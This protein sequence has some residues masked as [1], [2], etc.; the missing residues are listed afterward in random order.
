MVNILS[1][2][3]GI[4]GLDLALKL[5]LGDSART[6]AYVE[7]EAYCCEVLVARMDEG[8]LD[9]API[10]SDI[11]T[12]DGEAFRGKVDLVV[13]GFPCQAFSSAARGRNDRGRDLWPD[14]SRIV[15]ECTPEFV[16]LE[17]VSIEAFRGAY[18]DLRAMGYVV[19]PLYEADA[20][21]LGAPHSRRRFFLLA[22]TDSESKLERA[23]NGEVA[24][25]CA[26][27]GAWDGWPDIPRMD[28]GLPYRMD[29]DRALGN[30]VVPIQAA[31]A[32]KEL[33]KELP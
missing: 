6:V 30:A 21:E 28:D 8:H 9:M 12:F 7:R 32:F 27:Q 4:G 31:F 17:N 26:P 24:S 16:F 25:V 23:I 11:E 1:L 33:M 13:A 3:S 15:G 19:P 20:A 29:R 2:C 5:A 14:I 22:Y 18:D 10:W